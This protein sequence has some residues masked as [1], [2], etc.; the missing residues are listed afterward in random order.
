SAR[1]CSNAGSEIS[2]QAW[3]FCAVGVG[4]GAVVWHAVISSSASK[5]EAV[6]LKLMA[7]TIKHTASNRNA[8]FFVKY[9]LFARLALPLILPLEIRTI[10]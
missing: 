5:L 6:R 10:I 8:V 2:S 3:A 1:L 9:S 4:S 7:R